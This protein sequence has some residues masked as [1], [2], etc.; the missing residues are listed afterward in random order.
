MANIEAALNTSPL[1]SATTDAEGQYSFEGVPCGQYSLQVR[2]AWRHLVQLMSVAQPCCV[3]NC[4]LSWEQQRVGSQWVRQQ[5]APLP[6]HVAAAAA[7]AWGPAA[8]VPGAVAVDIGPWC[9]AYFNS[10]W[11]V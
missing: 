2:Q 9:A 7:A 4:R 11:H 6:V 3:S 10:I 1:C 5:G 8:Y